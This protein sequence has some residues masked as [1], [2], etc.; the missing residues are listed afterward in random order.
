[1]IGI[2]CVNEW[3]QGE[4]RPLQVVELGP[5]RGTLADDMLRVRT[6][7]GTSGHLKKK[8]T[9]KTHNQLSKKQ[10]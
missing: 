6:A 10:N 4:P 3:M 5:G 9:T 7:I 1:M 8:K 2:W